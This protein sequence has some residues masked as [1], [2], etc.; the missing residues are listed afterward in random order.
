MILK[1]PFKKLYTEPT[2]VEL[3]GLYVLVVPNIGRFKIFLIRNLAVSY[4]ESKERRYRK[5]AKMKELASIEEARLSSKN[6][7]E[8]EVKADS[9]GEKLAAQIVKNLQVIIKDIHIRYEDA[10]S[11]PGQTFSFGVTLSG[12]T[13]QTCD[14]SEHPVTIGNQLMREFYKVCFI[15]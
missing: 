1:I 9:F 13:F 14:N 11:I 10:Y 5:E 8:D 2:V 6:V 7:K 4:D 12:L 15:Y 3:T